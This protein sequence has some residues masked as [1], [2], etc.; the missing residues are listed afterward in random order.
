MPD[1]GVCA[2]RPDFVSRE[3]SG[4]QGCLQRAV[5]SCEL[6]KLRSRETTWP[7]SPQPAGGCSWDLSPG[8]A[9]PHAGDAGGAWACVGQQL[10]LRRGR[11][12][13]VLWPRHRQAPGVMEPLSQ[14]QSLPPGEP[15]EPA[16]PW[17]ACPPLPKNERSLLWGW[18]ELTEPGPQPPSS[19]TTHPPPLSPLASLPPHSLSPLPPL[20]PTAGVCPTPPSKGVV[21]QPLVPEWSP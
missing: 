2:W 18:G 14:P 21:T 15:R 17:C 20:K 5:S 12:E 16:T 11:L 3:S 1:F 19:R 9:L 6:G 7:Q 4:A 13:A 10:V 8:Q